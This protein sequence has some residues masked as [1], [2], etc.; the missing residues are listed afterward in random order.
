[1]WRTDALGGKENCKNKIKHD[2]QDHFKKINSKSFT[3]SEG[4]LYPM[5]RHQNLQ[6]AEPTHS[7]Q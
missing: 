3:A 6:F 5:I 2:I 1:M 7:M 4:I